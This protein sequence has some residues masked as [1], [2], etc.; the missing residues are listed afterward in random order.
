M[1]N[2]FRWA[3]G[4]LTRVL[5]VA[6]LGEDG[7]ST[8]QME[9]RGGR[10]AAG[11]GGEVL[12]WGNHRWG[13]DPFLSLLTWGQTWGQLPPLSPVRREEASYCRRKMHQSFSIR[14]L[15]GVFIHQFLH[16]LRSFI[17][18]VL[19]TADNGGW[20]WQ[21][22]CPLRKQTVNNKMRRKPRRF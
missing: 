9:R 3:K 12:G 8:G 21:G 16:A 7:R 4:L 10:E 20:G 14:L 18:Y 5:G 1:F 22:P 2:H 19:D 15:K 6:E 13:P 17:H 11:L